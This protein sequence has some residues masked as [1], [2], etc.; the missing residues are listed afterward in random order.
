[1]DHNDSLGSHWWNKKAVLQGVSKLFKHS[2]KKN[3][4]SWKNEKFK[5]QLISGLFHIGDTTAI[6]PPTTQGNG[7]VIED[8]STSEIEDVLDKT[9]PF[10]EYNLKYH[11]KVWDI[12]LDKKVNTCIFWNKNED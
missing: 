4:S 2:L 12:N 7:H 6:L 10:K 8:L 9:F 11:S 3:S 1:M 5:H